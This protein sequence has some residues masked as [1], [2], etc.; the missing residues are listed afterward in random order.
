EMALAGDE[1]VIDV[2]SGLGQLTRAIA[3]QVRPG[4]SVVGIERSPEQLAESHRL[5]A[6]G[7]EERL[8]EFRQGNAEQ[9]PLRDDEWGTFDVAHTR[10][11]L[12]HVPDPA[13][14]V[15]QMIRAVRPGGRIILEDDAHDTH[16]LWPE[17]PGFG[18]LWSAY[19]RTYDRLGN[20]PFVGRRLV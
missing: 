13:T 9:L 4:G 19:L 12:E 17:P 2:G 7:G 16:C 11:L 8:V 10:F 3:L 5:A 18:R 1:R 6:I 20:D 14:V 15:R